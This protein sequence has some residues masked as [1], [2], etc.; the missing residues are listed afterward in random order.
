MMLI[1]GA[2]EIPRQWSCCE[3]SDPSDYWG[4]EQYGGSGLFGHMTETD[5]HVSCSAYATV[6]RHLRDMEF[7]GWDEL[8]TRTV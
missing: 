3:I 5:P 2:N 4:E 8:P 7:E 1:L 6:I